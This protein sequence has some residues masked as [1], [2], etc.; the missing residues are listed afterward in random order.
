MIGGNQMLMG[1]KTQ[2]NYS[3]FSNL[4]TEGGQTNHFLVPAGRFFLSDYQNDLV[5][6]ESVVGYPPGLFPWQ[7]WLGEGDRRVRRNS[8]WLP[9][10]FS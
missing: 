3:M 4:R 1:L 5:R 7:A 8:R 6:V 10:S 9:D 2:A